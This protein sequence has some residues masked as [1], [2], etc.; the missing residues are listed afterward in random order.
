MLKLLAK[1]S[2]SNTMASADDPSICPEDFF[3]VAASLLGLVESSKDMTHE[4][5]PS[6]VQ[7]HRTIGIY[8]LA[9]TSSEMT[10]FLTCIACI[11]SVTGSNVES[12]V[13]AVKSKPSHVEILTIE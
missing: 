1:V 4:V 11:C 13:T 2:V 5:E 9:A 12:R 7:S 8:T 10:S 3:H 6:R